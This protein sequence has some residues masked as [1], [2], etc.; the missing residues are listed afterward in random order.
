MLAPGS[1][2]PFNVKIHNATGAPEDFFLDPR[3][4]ASAAG[5]LAPLVPNPLTLP[6][7]P[8]GVPQERLVPTQSSARTIAAAAATSAG[9][10]PPGSFPRDPHL[11]SGLPTGG[12]NH[13]G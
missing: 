10:V 3:L 2:H 6:L 8:T 13:P 1:T 12:R 11:F 4:A 9:T 7:P 5:S